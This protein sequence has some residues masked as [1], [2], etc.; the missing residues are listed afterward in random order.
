M[1]TA[2]FYLE[3]GFTP[4][5]RTVLVN[6]AETIAVWTPTTST[7]VVLT[8]LQITS[9][10]QGGTLA[11]YFGN[12]AGTKIFEFALSTT[13]T[14]SPGIGPIESTMYDRIVFVKANPGGDGL[15]RVNLQGFELP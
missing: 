3:K 4:A 14:I 15:Y 11:F 10:A 6:S 13:T 12:L 8:D 7:R 5:F 1:S 9:T 2:N